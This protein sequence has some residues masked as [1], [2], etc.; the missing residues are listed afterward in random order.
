MVVTPG[1]MLLV[2]SGWSSKDAAKYPITTDPT[3]TAKNDLTQNVNSAQIEE[4]WLRQV[5]NAFGCSYANKMQAESL[6]IKRLSGKNNT[7]KC[8][9]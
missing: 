9:C 3:P 5:V 6:I 7:I 2:S 8:V 4:L 1:E